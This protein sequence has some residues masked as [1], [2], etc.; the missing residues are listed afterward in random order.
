M[1]DNAVIESIKS[2]NES[3]LETVYKKYRQ[4]FVAWAIKS[5]AC[6][7]EQAVD[8]YQ[9]SIMVFYEN[10][11]KGKLT[12]LSSSVKTYLFA[13]G[14]NK[15]MEQKRSA[16]KMVVGIDA[17]ESY[18][19]GQTTEDDDRQEEMLQVVEMGLGELGD[20]CHAILRNYYYHKQSMEEIA[21]AMD[22]KN[23]E[24]VKNLKYKCIKRL[25]KIVM[26]KHRG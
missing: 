25:R 8:A 3:A 10:I 14:K 6:T 12:E 15:V 26:L 1:G 13:V 11:M 18:L 23:A 7:N 24:T 2:G 9:S 21:T 17:H 5:Y 4:E 20:P 19:K 22:Y 16:Q